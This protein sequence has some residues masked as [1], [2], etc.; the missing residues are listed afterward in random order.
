MYQAGS[1][2]LEI[3]KIVFP[4]TN[5]LFT[6]PYEVKRRVRIGLPLVFNVP[7]RK[8]KASQNKFSDPIT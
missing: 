4:N 2:D 6:S 1:H 5:F 3:V 8:T 7:A